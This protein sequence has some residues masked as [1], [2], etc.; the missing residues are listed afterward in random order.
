M[1]DSV[2]L[3]PRSI[4]V[5]GASDR[6]GS[7]G[8]AI[9]SNI[10]HY[11]TGSVYPVNPG[12]REVFGL[13][14]VSSVA[15]IVEPVD[16]AVVVT[17][18]N[19]VCEVLEDCGRKGIRGAIV[20]TSGFGEVNEEGRRLE[21][22]MADVA[23]HHN[24]QVVGPNCLGVMN[25][26]PAIMLNATFLKFT[27]RSGNIALVSQSG[28][29]CAALVENAAAQGIGFSAIFSMG[30]KAVMGETEILDIL[31]DHAATRVIVMYLE[32]IADGAA[33]MRSCRR[34]TREW[35]KPVMVL[36]AGRSVAGARAAMSHTGAM[37]GSDEVAE[38]LLAQSGAIRV[39]T[40]SELFD[41]ASAFSMQPLPQKES[42]VIL[43]N[44]GG[45]AIVSTDACAR[46][47]IP[48]ADI[49]QVRP[50]IDAL[51]PPW[52]SSRN[53]VDIVGDADFKRFAKVMDRVMAQE[54][55]GAVVA[56]CTPSATLDYDRLAGA[57]V[58]TA[59]RHNKT[60]LASL[61]GDEEGQENRRILR[62]G[63]VPHYRYAEDAVSALG[64]MM[65]FRGWLN[66]P[67]KAARDFDM[68]METVSR[69][70]DDALAAGRDHLLETEGLELMRACGFPLPAYELARD[71]DAAAAAGAA[72]GFPV[73]MKIV[74]AAIVHKTEAGGV[75]VKIADAE[76]ARRAFDSLMEAA[77][78]YD[79]R[80]DVA[81]VLVVEMVQSGQEMIVGGRRE[82]R[83]GP[84]V[85]LGA[86]GIH[87]EVF[88]DAA[89][90]VAPVSEA[91]ARAMLTEVR[92]ARLLQG[93]RG[94][95]PA[96]V[97]ALAE[98]AE[99]CSSLML[100]CPRIRE[101]DMN[102]V[103]VLEQGRGCR[104]LDIRVGVGE[105]EST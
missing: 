81:G 59:A 94:V 20:V 65:R 67:L 78:R 72:I 7:V 88:K 14:A 48:L 18:N 53:P 63:G 105:I 31:A 91:E 27:P 104:V 68:H 28:A 62:E 85:M 19:L 41:Y 44:A 17:K 60:V 11:F 24:I 93:F 82:P 39:N 3:S 6:E 45:A 80:A 47:E 90:R 56:M 43:S 79:P 55:V 101:M 32:D 13:P 10:I 36:K 37:M 46:L 38:A 102:P 35:R 2:F 25:L 8:R 57:I 9:T 61:M 75:I 34:V 77:H 64:A 29:V 33:F 58:E 92:A 23:R 98:C 12:R 15:D 52:G 22:E 21:K 4:A 74:S 97:D 1:A 73:V 83:I 89:Y 100:A 50:E 42:A 30:N 26:D 5:V 96:D 16:L 99:R 86:G 70:I 71:A 51:I 54:N 95:P 103:R 66:T 76:A 40:L 84:V 69:V 87:V 49:T